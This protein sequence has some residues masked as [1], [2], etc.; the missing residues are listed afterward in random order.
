MLLN[1][2][3]KQSISRKGNCLDNVVMENFFEK[4]KDEIFYRYENTFNSLNK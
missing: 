3:I 1:K 2:N 4:I